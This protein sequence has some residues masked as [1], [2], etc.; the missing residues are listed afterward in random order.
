LAALA[1]PA[2]AVLPC[3]QPQTTPAATQ[4]AT[5]SFRNHACMILI[6]PQCWS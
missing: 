4:S 2:I 1:V 6:L 3:W 5:L